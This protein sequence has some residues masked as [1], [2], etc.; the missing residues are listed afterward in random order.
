MSPEDIV[1]VQSTWVQGA[2]H[3]RQC[4][5]RAPAAIQPKGLGMTIS[6]TKHER[7]DGSPGSASPVP[8][9]KRFR[10][11]AGRVGATAWCAP[12][13]LE[14]SGEHIARIEDGRGMLVYVRHG[15]V[16][17]TQSGVTRDYFVHAGQSLRLDRNGLTL[18]SAASGSS[19]ALV[20]LVPSYRTASSSAERVEG[21]MRRLWARL[22]P[23]ALSAGSSRA[24]SRE[25]SANAVH[26][27]A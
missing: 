6:H 19:P 12:I 7:L 14:I 26:V 8:G 5:G 3:E 4:Q 10:P 16:W 24:Q 15:A 23:V 2:V 27:V 25:N 21:G 9:Q 13:D 20:A 22:M 17:I 11:K 1:T 18:L